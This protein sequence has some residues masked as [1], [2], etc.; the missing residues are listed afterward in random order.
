MTEPTLEKP[1]KSV[2]DVLDS[3]LPSATAV[4]GRIREQQTGT[5]PFQTPSKPDSFDR[6]EDDLRFPTGDLGGYPDKDPKK[7]N[8]LWLVL[9]GVALIGLGVGTYFIIKKNK[10]V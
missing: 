5:N 6:E 1:K 4:Y 3:L 2:W 10:N 8:K 7:S 9:G